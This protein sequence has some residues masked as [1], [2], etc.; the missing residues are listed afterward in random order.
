MKILHFVFLIFEGS[1][2]KLFFMKVFSFQFFVIV[3]PMGQNT[4]VSIKL[5][6]GKVLNIDL[7]STPW[8]TTIVG[9]QVPL[10]LDAAATRLFLINNDKTIFLG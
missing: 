1:N 3:K 5:F 8:S 2:K 9:I 4:F 7:Y 10:S 6:S